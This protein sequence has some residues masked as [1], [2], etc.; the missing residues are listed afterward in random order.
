M[1]ALFLLIVLFPLAAQAQQ[2]APHPETAPPAQAIPPPPDPQV[3]ALWQ[4]LSEEVQA[5]VALR[6]EIIRLQAALAKAQGPE[7]PK[8]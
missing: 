4:K 2:A 7:G 8:E 5:N 3:Q 6:A 1:R